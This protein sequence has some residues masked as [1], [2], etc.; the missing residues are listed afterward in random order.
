MNMKKKLVAGGLVAALA[1]TAIGGATLAYFTD[2]DNRTNTF[3]VAG[4]GGKDALGITM[5]ETSVDRTV[6]EDGEDVKL[7]PAT[8][9]DGS[10]DQ[11]F[12]YENMVPGLAYDKNVDIDLDEDSLDS[13][14][15]VEL[16]ITNFKELSALMTSGGIDTTAM[17]DAFLVNPSAYITQNNVLATKLAEDGD[18]YSMVF[19]FGVMSETT[20]VTHIDVFDGVKVPANLTADDMGLLTK[21]VNLT[22]KA[23][24]IQNA[25]LEDD[26]AADA[27][28]IAEWFSDYTVA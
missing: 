12:T 5:T 10:I 23:Y 3:A 13:H 9:G 25:G 22:I 2:T 15:Y 11:G 6:Q 27:A 4:Q 7:Y 16:T 17:Q 20:D 14:L 18:T 1:A 26:A 8:S 19:D 28:A 21:G 24:A